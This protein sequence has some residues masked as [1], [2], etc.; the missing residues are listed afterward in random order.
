MT[1]IMACS[2]ESGHIFSKTGFLAIDSSKG[3]IFKANPVQRG[4]SLLTARGSARKTELP[5]RGAG[6]S[7]IL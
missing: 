6:S 2:K 4:C 3:T 1:G 7:A 5:P